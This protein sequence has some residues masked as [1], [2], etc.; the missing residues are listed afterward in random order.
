MPYPTQ[1]AGRLNANE[2][3]ASIFNMII[4]Q[5]VFADNIKD[6]KSSLVDAA[7]V[8]GSMY[9]DTKLYYATDVLRS[10][11]WGGDA[12]AANL[13]A[14]DRPEDPKCQAITLDVFRQ[15]RLTV[16]NYLTKRAWSTENAFNEFN[17]VMLGWIRDTKKV[18]DSTTYNAFIGTYETA[19][20][21][22]TQTVE[23]PTDDTNQ[24]AENRLQAQAI[25]TK[26][27]DILVDLE[28]VSRDYNDYENLRSYSADDFRYVWNAA[29]VNKIRKLDL[30]TIF[31]KDFIDKFAEYTL[32]ARY[33]GKIGGAGTEGEV[34]A[35]GLT[36]RSLV[37]QDVTL[38]TP[39]VFK[40]QT[41][42]SGS[43][44]HVFAGDIIP[45]GVIV[46]TPGGVQV[47]YY[48]EDS[49]I[50]CKIVH[51]SAVP[52]MSGFEAGTSF[53]NPRSL[54]EN[55]YLTFAHNTIEALHDK[56]FITLKAEVSE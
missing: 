1:Y 23:L 6:T 47:P 22:Q 20:G 13:L 54:T 39:Y 50:V 51:K 11:A 42:S 7:R 17:S 35:D 44:F 4:S 29:Y 30:P 49:S 26:V 14:L 15:I 52:Y 5:Q 53:F 19:E 55:H 38:T 33:F 24:E 43:K 10:Y 48:T 8:D 28:D 9:G 36:I 40:G 46:A 12:E 18:Y 34:I 21:K 45:A 31:H 27:A 32:P 2:I 37:E 16:D 3:F 56:P 25:A 41:I